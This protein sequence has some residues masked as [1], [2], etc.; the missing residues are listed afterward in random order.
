MIYPNGS[1][2]EQGSGIRKWVVTLALFTG[3]VAQAMI[4]GQE[5]LTKEYI[6]L[7]GKLIAIENSP[8]QS[9]AIDPV[10]GLN[11]SVNSTNPESRI[12][13]QWSSYSGEADGLKIERKEGAEGYSIIITGLSTSTTTYSDT[14]LSPGTAYTYRLIAYEGTNESVPSNE[15]CAFGKRA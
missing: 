8:G 2:I 3:F 14:G 5:Q 10:T 9:P 15:A 1:G 12:D 4:F 13:L 11:A 6:Y 7:N